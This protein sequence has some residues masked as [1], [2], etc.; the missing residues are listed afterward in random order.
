MTIIVT[1][2][3][4]PAYI[5]VPSGYR[6]RPV[7]K[8]LPDVRWTVIKKMVT[9]AG[10]DGNVNRRAVMEAGRNGN[11]KLLKSKVFCKNV[12]NYFCAINAFVWK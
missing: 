3:S 12:L 1:L 2:T 8:F 10:R 4:R 5:T 9:E 11:G 6:D 7:L